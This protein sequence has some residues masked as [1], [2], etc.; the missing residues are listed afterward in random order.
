M[1]ENNIDLIMIYE[2]NRNIKKKNIHQDMNIQ[3]IFIH[4]I[5]K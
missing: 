2:W 1:K 3:I 4:V 5:I